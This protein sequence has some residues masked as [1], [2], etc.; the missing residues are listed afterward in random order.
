MLKKLLWVVPI[1]LALSVSRIE[2]KPGDTHHNP[3]K[4]SS[5]PE[6]DPGAA[7]AGLALLL[8]GAWVLSG[9]LRRGP[10]QD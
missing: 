2:A 6:F 3:P 9:R 8:G 10:N 4:R 7:G 5:A 1:A